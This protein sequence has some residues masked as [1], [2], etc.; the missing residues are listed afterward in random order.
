MKPINDFIKFA[1]SHAK[2][3]SVPKAASLL[4]PLDFVGSAG[5]WEYLMGTS[6]KLV[7]QSLLD[8]RWK[9]YYSTT[10]WT[11][12]SYLKATA[13][14]VE[15]GVIACDCQG[16]LDH[17]LGNDTSANGNYIKYCTDKGKITEINRPWVIGEAVFNGS[18]TKKTHVGWVCGFMPNGEP[19]V[20]HARGLAYGV[21]INSFSEFKWTYRGLMT[22]IFKYTEDKPMAKIIKI[23]TPLMRGSDIKALQAALNGLGYDCGKADGIAGENTLRAIKAFVQAHSEPQAL[24]DKLNVHI[25][26]GSTVYTGTIKR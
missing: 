16:L 15:R 10:Q 1:L 24:P 9:N 3:A 26:A 8:E 2:R 11:R 4:T 18:E 25:T 23:T 17:Y 7:T 5:E 21:V 20:V 22:N 19:V 14:W 12:E 6:G 13:G